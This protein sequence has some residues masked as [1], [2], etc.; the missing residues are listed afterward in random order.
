MPVCESVDE[1]NQVIDIEANFEEDQDVVHLCVQGQDP[2]LMS[3]HTESD[4]EIEEDPAP[5]GYEFESANEF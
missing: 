1:E 5:P 3:D 2:E 4:G